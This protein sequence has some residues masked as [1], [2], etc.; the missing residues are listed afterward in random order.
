[1]KISERELQKIMFEARQPNGYWSR[2]KIVRAL[3]RA[4]REGA[5]RAKPT[6]SIAH[7]ILERSGWKTPN[8]KV[9]IS[10]GSKH[11]GATLMTV[12][13]TKR[14][15]ATVEMYGRT[16]ANIMGIPLTDRRIK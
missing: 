13:D 4:Y 7:L 9:H 3:Q 6:L 16:W 15:N 10:I 11:G 2:V 1:M 12:G 14:G 5:K 8:P